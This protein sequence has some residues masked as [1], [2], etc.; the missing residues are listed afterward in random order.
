VLGGALWAILLLGSHVH[1][2]TASPDRSDCGASALSIN[3][4]GSSIGGGELRVDQDAFDR[5]CVDR[6][7][8]R[9]RLSVLP[10][11][12][13]GLA[14]VATTIDRRRGE[15]RRRGDGALVQPFGNAGR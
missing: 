9:I 1:A 6:A 5:A 8:T 2:P 14:L 10:A 3:A 11:S 13:F 12:I 15:A 4:H 7:R